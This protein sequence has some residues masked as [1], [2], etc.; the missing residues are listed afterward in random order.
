LALN[1]GINGFILNR[2]KGKYLSGIHLHV[3]KFYF[4]IQQVTH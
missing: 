1:C 3:M 4:V 2:K